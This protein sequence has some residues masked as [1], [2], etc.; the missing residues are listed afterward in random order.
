MSSTE[1]QPLKLGLTD[2]QYGAR[3]RPLVE[4]ECADAATHVR[5]RRAELDHLAE[6][7]D[8]EGRD[9]EHDPDGA[10]A[11]FSHSMTVGLLA[12][13]QRRLDEA[14]AARCRLDAGTY[15]RCATCNGAIT[16]ERLVALPTARECVSC[17][18]NVRPARP[19]RRHR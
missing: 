19:L 13:A 4:A 2:V 11:A 1:P 12:T 6:T 7:T 15:G 17:A 9:D 8:I 14:D 5:R 10:T 16:D 18:A 3:W